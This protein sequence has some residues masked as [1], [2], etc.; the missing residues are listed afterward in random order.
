M[1]KYNTSDDT[2]R[3]F[4][5]LNI[6]QIFSSPYN[7]T[8]NSLSERINKSISDILTINKGL[9]IKNIK[10]VI[11]NRLNKIINTTTKMTSDEIIK[12]NLTLNLY[13]NKNKR[14]FGINHVYKEG[15][16]IL[17]RKRIFKKI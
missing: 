9:E 2:K 7:P 6:Q 10:E 5:N 13:K 12:N 1:P 16:E 17:I 14:K 4:S 8:C 15:D 11:E 3:F